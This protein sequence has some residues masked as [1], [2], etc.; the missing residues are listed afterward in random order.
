MRSVAYINSFLCRKT[1]TL[2]CNSRFVT[3]IT[4]LKWI[5]I[6]PFSVPA[7]NQ[8]RIGLILYR[9]CFRTIGAVS[10][11]EL[12]TPTCCCFAIL[13]GEQS[14]FLLLNLVNKLKQK[15]NIYSHFLH[16]ANVKESPNKRRH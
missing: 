11:L 3:L 6:V 13:I 8:F 16:K 10:L 14:F 1:T 15:Q 12:Y 4:L 5:T 7:S 9:N 2:K